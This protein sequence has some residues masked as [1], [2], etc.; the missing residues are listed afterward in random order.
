MNNEN[1]KLIFQNNIKNEKYTLQFLRKHNVIIY[2]A[3]S[4]FHWVLELLIIKNNIKPVLIIDEK[5]SKSGFFHNIK[6]ISFDHFVFDEKKNLT[7]LI[8]ITINNKNLRTEIKNKFIN[9]G[10]NNV[11]FLYE[12]YQIHNPFNSENNILENII[13]IE[14]A[15]KLLS[16][17]KSKIIYKSIIEIHHTKFPVSVPASPECEQYFPLDISL[18]NDYS[19]VISC[20]SGIHD[21]ENIL[22]NTGIDLGQLICIEPD[23]NIF[24]GGK[25][26]EG[27]INYVKKRKLNIKLMNNAVSNYKGQ[28]KFYS[29]GFNLGVRKYATSFGSK[30]NIDGQELI[31]VISL[32]DLIHLYK[33]S[34]ICIDAEGEDLNILRGGENIIKKNNP[35]IAVSVY[36][37]I[38]HIW[39]SILYLNEI[40][41]HYN[42][43]IRNYTG[44]TMETVVYGTSVS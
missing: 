12:I 17:E 9:L 20:G 14:K 11:I 44:F 19:T 8:I 39:E 36:H 3:G 30:I 25:G 23:G 43:Y 4:S 26:Y 22:R 16:D 42:F 33:P 40:C 21:I 6:S 37:C 1:L 29:S 5:F 32:D 15:Y 34:F 31:D 10:Y 35:D 27:I 13:N 2:G 41:P 18:K 28:S 38:S 7:D 24:Y